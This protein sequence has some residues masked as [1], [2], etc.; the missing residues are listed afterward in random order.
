MK[1]KHAAFYKAQLGPSWSAPFVG[2]TWSAFLAFEQLAATWYMA[3]SREQA[4]LEVAMR[5]LL[6]VFQKSELPA[7]RM[8]IYAAGHESGMRTLW[9]R[10]TGSQE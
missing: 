3:D 7:V 4:Y 10:L 8:A 1:S 9:Y 2:S 6:P 5:A